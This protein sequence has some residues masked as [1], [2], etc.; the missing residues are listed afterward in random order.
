MKL[1]AATFR[2]TFGLAASVPLAYWAI[3]LACTSLLWAL[4]DLMAHTLHAG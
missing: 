3:G 4:M 1:L 2:H